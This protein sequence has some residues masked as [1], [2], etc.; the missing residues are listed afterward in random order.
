MPLLSSSVQLT[1]LR[2]SVTSDGGV[3]LEGTDEPGVALPGEGKGQQAESPMDRLS[4]LIANL[5]EVFGKELGDADKI[6]IEQ[7]KVTVMADP[8]M[9]SIAEE[10]DKAQYT[11]A[12]EAK[13]K[14]LIV[15]RHESNG[16]LFD[17]FFDNPQFAKVMMNYLAETYEA[18]RATA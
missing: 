9:R 14:D 7:Q 8:E 6:W 1:H 5:N 15:E 11:V 17:A 3:E 4:V 16:V 2:T 18:F 13:I 10:N 12:L